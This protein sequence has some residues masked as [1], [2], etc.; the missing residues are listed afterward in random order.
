VSL[1]ELQKNNETT[2][3]CDLIVL[4]SY[5]STQSLVTQAFPC[6]FILCVIAFMFPGKLSRLAF[7]HMCKITLKW[8]P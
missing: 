4:S 8:K 1:P 7:F 5:P 2:Q 6:H 3:K